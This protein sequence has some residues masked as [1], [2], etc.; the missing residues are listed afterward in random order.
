[1]DRAPS[2]G[3]PGGPSAARPRRAAPRPANRATLRAD[4]TTGGLAEAG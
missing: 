3:P 1:V 4:V 2:G